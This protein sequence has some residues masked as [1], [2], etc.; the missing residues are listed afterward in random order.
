MLRATDDIYS[1]N[2]LLRILRFSLFLF[3]AIENT[4]QAI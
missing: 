2:N 3:Q 4:F 1:V